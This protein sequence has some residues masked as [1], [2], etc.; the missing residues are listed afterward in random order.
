MPKKIPV[1]IKAYPLSNDDIQRILKPD[2]HI[3]TYPDFAR[4]DSIDEAFDSL[5][6]CIFL[7]LTES[8]SVGHWLCMLRRGGDI[9][10]WDSYGEPPEAQRSWLS[11]A[12][13]E[14]LGEGR[15]YLLNLLKRS[16]CKVFYN[17]HKYQRSSS[18]DNECGRW[19]VA[20]LICKDLDNDQF[21]ALVERGM[22]DNNLQTP[23]DWVSAF[24]ADMLGK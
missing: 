4:F 8:R 12:E 24:I 13:L 18:V 16:G 23:D 5:G 20:R 6:R 2:T 17:T 19:C 14:A 3:F 11:Q 1:E 10:Y 9:E 15:P 22:K 21:L 7:F